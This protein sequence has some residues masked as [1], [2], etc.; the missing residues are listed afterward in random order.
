[1]PKQHVAVPLLE[2]VHSSLDALT[3]RCPTTIGGIECHVLLPAPDPA[4]PS[5]GDGNLKAPHDEHEEHDPYWTRSTGWPDAR[6]GYIHHD[7]VID[8]TH[9][10]TIST[11]GLIPL[12]EPI[13]WDGRCSTSTRRSGSGGTCCVTG[14]Q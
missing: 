3:L 6:W 14:C 11:V 4:W 8:G 1:M 13:P 7:S 10:A 2:S 5:A 9:I 12:S